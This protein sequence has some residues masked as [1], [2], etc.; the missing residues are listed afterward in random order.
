VSDP[1]LLLSALEALGRLLLDLHVAGD[2]LPFS[3]F[4]REALRLVQAVLPFDSAIWGVGTYQPNGVPQIFSVFL[5]NQPKEMIADYDRVKDGDRAFAAALTEPGITV[6]VAAADVVWGPYGEGMKAHIE[7]YGMVHTLAT[8]T[9]GPIT[10]LA[11]A[12]CLY[13]ADPAAPFSE[14]ERAM[15]QVL[16]P[17]LVSVYDRSRIQFLA[18]A[19]GAGSRQPQGGAAIVDGHGML[20]NASSGFIRL[21][22]SEWPDWRG[23]IVPLDL[24]GADALRSSTLNRIVARATPVND[25]F[26]LDLREITPCDNLSEREWGVARAFAEGMSYKEVALHLRI[27]PATVRNHLSRVYTKLGV[28]NKAELVHVLETSL[29]RPIASRPT[30][31]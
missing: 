2:A 19:Q 14:I 25:L 12:I 18:N 24:L 9:R 26:L 3:D 1:D 15:Q 4:Q 8:L 31:A 11:S 30:V 23:P 22:L 17:H 29:R 16:V 27:A 7:R 13:R 5:L 10:E 28:S 20:H 21:L 6:N